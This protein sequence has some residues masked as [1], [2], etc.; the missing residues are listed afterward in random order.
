MATGW[1]GRHTRNGA[2]V[3]ECPEPYCYYRIRLRSA[4]DS[5]DHKCPFAGET[6]VGWSVTKTLVEQVWDM[7]D[8]SIDEIMSPS[9]LPKEYHQ[10]Q[11]R[12]FCRVLAIFMKPLFADEDAIADEARKRY[13]MRKAGEPYETIGLGSLRHAGLPGAED[14]PRSTSAKA[15]P[16]LSA[17]E[18]AVIKQ[19]ASS[20]MFT[21]EEL[22]NVYK[23]SLEQVKQIVSG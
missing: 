5:T 17:Q 19:A 2:E 23:I 9:P 6:R 3:F 1:K 15:P 18:R 13:K 12:A 4:G 11:A 21:N 22:S 16:P 7:L 20:G 10:A 14:K 8:R